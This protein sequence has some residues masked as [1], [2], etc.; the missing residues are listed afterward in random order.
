LDRFPLAAVHLPGVLTAYHQQ[1]ERIA[2]IANCYPFHVH[3]LGDDL[4]NTFR[5]SIA[6]ALLAAGAA[7]AQLVNPAPS[8]PQARPSPEAVA[9]AKMPRKFE[10][11]YIVDEGAHPF[12]SLFDGYRTDPRLVAGINLNRYLALEAGYAERKDRG[13]HR[14]GRHSIVDPYSAFDETGALG[15]DGFY[16]YAAVKA[17]APIDGDLSAYGKLGVAHSERRGDDALGRKKNANVDTG[18]Y[19]GLG[20]QY[21]LSEKAAVSMEGQKFG[22]TPEKWGKDSNGNRVN[23]KVNLGF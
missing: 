22:H 13:F 5:T 1:F 8:A 9:F 6:L 10:R 19:T 12:T 16:S 7:Q 15:I 20:A 23:A 3:A 2:R 17:T 21:K 14:A 4:M 18:L 11:G